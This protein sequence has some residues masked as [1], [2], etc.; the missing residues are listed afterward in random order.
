M[1]SFCL[2]ILL[3]IFSAS[4]LFSQHCPESGIARE[5]YAQRRLR[6]AEIIDTAAVLIMKTPEPATEHEYMNFWQDPDFLYL[7]GIDEP[8]FGLIIDPKGI[9][10]GGKNWKSILFVPSS[11]LEGNSDFSSQESPFSSY[12][13]EHDTVMDQTA[14]RS[15][16]SKVMIGRKTLFYSAPGLSFLH[17]WINDK[18]YFLEKDIQ[19]ALKQK[20]PGLKMVKASTQISRMRQLKSPAELELMR[21]AIDLTGD[22]ISQAM[23]ACKPGIWEY[24]IQ[25]EV[26]YSMRKGGAERES[27]RSIIGAGINS[28]SPHYDDN[29]CRMKAGEVLVMDVGAEYHHY[30]AD[31]TRTIP[32]SGKFSPAQKTIY[33]AVLQVQKELISMIR[34]GIAMMKIDEM[35]IEL[36]SRAGYKAY[37]IHGVTHPVGLDVHDVSVS[38]VLEPGMVITIEPGIYIPLNDTLLSPDFRGFGIRIEDDILVTEDGYE[39]LSKDIPREAGEIERL[40]KK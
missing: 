23:K 34:P 1:K 7:T 19:K 18:P 28:L 11:S 14:F 33:E 17:D 25:A 35:A 22:G 4:Y 12:V 26:E 5:E 36:I 16:F 13:G 6:V 38:G 2:G 37:I 40:M 39:V 10:I 20:F 24:E 8:G 31:I 29:H 32:V 9:S 15:V 21:R 30:A 3:I 27:F